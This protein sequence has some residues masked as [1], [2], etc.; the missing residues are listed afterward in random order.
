MYE[1]ETYDTVLKRLLDRIPNTIDKREGSV[2]YMVLAPAAYEIARLYSSLDMVL[3]ETFADTASRYFL[4]KRAAE[5]KITPKQ[6]TCAVLKGE[7]DK[8]IPVGTRFSGGTLN[9]RISEVIDEDSELFYYKVTCETEGII[10]N[11]YIGRLIPISDIDEL[12]TANLTEILIH[13]TDAEDTETFRKRYLQSVYNQSFGGNVSDYKNYMMQLQDV[14]G[15]KVYPVWNGAGTVKV[16]F[17]NSEYGAP[18]ETLVE[19]VQ[20]EIDP[21]EYTGM[22][23]G[24]A[25]IDHKV[26]VE[27]AAEEVINISLKCRFIENYKWTD[28]SEQINTVVKDYFKELNSE[29]SN[30]EDEQEI[31]VRITQ[32][33][34]RILDIYGIEDILE[35]KI[36]GNVRNYTVGEN[37]VIKLGAVT[38]DTA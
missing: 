18:S 24:M 37:S 2:V 33:E 17:V 4:V 9:Y 3:N 27:G 16:V 38:N 5:R 31:I 23:I 32:I 8:Q 10:G 13:G 20:K 1:S 21:P 28:V 26:T 6:P 22:G 36:N 12:K 11:T 30:W 34:S 7:F 19:Y 15:S 29:W 35:T 14:G 25:P